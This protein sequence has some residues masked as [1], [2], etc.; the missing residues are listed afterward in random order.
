MLAAAISTAISMLHLGVIDNRVAVLLGDV[1]G[2]VWLVAVI[3]SLIML[4]GL[5]RASSIL[6]YLLPVHGS[7]VVG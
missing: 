6:P 3:D 7:L 2:H 5:M 1:E 4:S